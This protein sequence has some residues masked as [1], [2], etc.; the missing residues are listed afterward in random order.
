M[1]LTLCV[2]YYY[3]SSICFGILLVLL[4]SIS[5]RDLSSLSLLFFLCY[6]KSPSQSSYQGVLGVRQPLLS[7]VWKHDF[8]V[9][10]PPTTSLLMTASTANT[11]DQQTLLRLKASAKSEQWLNSNK[12]L[13]R[14]INPFNLIRENEEYPAMEECQA[15]SIGLC[16]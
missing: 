10:S 13:S 5:K 2:L 14:T 6:D 11:S 15:K 1:L 12:S 4:R 7:S 8:H 9:I 3:Y 16:P